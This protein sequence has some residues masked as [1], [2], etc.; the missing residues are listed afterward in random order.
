MC[1]LTLLRRDAHE[2]GELGQRQ[3]RPEGPGRVALGTIGRG[4]RTLTRQFFEPLSP[5]VGA[6]V[7]DAMK[8]TR[9]SISLSESASG[10][11][12]SSRNRS[13]MPSPLL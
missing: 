6:R 2:I 10:W 1:P 11:M 5:V 12:S 3:F 7:S 8:A 9:S 4:H 13:W